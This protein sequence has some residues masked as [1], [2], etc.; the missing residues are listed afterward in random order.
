[1]MKNL[2]AKRH[3]RKGQCIVEGCNG[4]IKARQLCGMHYMRMRRRKVKN[5]DA[6]SDLIVNCLAVGC[7]NTHFAHG[8]CEDHDKIYM[9]FGYPH[10]PKVIKQ[11]G[12][13]NCTNIHF[14]NGLCENHYN[15]W[16]DNLNK[17]QLLGQIENKKLTVQ[18]N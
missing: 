11:C 7:S 10:I 4:H 17:H 6:V 18:Y 14:K 3:S 16:K 1:M 8:Y 15:Q 9:K 5:V 13:A 2:L 12:V